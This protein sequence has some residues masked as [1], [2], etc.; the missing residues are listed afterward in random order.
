MTKESL[1]P[2]HCAGACPRRLNADTSERRERRQRFLFEL[3]TGVPIQ[4]VTVAIALHAGPIDGQSHAKGMR[5]PPSDL[6]IG[7]S[8]LEAWLKRRD[9]QRPPLPTD[10]QTDVIQL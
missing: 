1:F 9:R 3:L 5:I 8:A 4:P 6:L 10:P 7:A 2:T